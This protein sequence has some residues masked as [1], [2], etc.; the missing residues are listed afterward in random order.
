M[1][2][3]DAAR[4]AYCTELQVKAQEA[5]QNA[6]RDLLK[7]QP[8]KLEAFQELSD[9]LTRYS[10]SGTDVFR[11]TNERWKSSSWYGGDPCRH[12]YFSLVGQ[13]WIFSFWEY[14]HTSEQTSRMNLA[15]GIGGLMWGYVHEYDER[16]TYHGLPRGGGWAF[17]DPW[18]EEDRSWATRYQTY[19]VE[20]G[21][22]AL[23]GRWQS[24]HANLVQLP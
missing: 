2:L 14:D 22:E 7:S 4:A 15:F 21:K 6:R 23:A 18:T 1:N 9:L 5:E 3:E 11:I 10:V 8:L 13:G 24:G 19:V 12:T 20:L 17:T 16:R